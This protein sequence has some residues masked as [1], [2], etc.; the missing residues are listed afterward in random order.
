MKRQHWVL[1]AAIAAAGVLTF[2]IVQPDE[3]LIEAS[4]VERGQLQVTIDEDGVTRVRRHAE[5]TAPVSGRLAESRVRAGDSVVAGSVIARL[6]PAPLDPRTRQQASAALEAARALTREATQRVEQAE[7]ALDEARRDRRR[8]EALAGAGALSQRELEQAIDKERVQAREL[9]AAQSRRRAAGEEE[10]SAEAALRGADP[11]TPMAADH[12][13]LRAPMTGRVL[14]VF[15]EHD[16][17]VPAG[18]PLLEL[19]DTRSIEIVVDLLTRDAALVSVGARMVVR[20][21]DEPPLDAR[22]VRVEPAAFTKVSPLGIE[23][24]RVNVIAQFVGPPSGFGDGFEVQ[25]A[26]V[27]WEGEVTK[28]PASALV[29][30]DSGWAAYVVRNNRAN[31]RAVTIGRRGSRDVEVR[32]GVSPGDVVVLHPDERLRDGSRVTA[33]GR[34]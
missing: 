30:L 14:R 2:V 34:H 32:S 27:L 33:G 23:E 16:R 7:V 12:V 22:V 5:V 10:R 8:S 31:L 4:T 25:S 9:A 1:A 26:I 20:T 28:L 24:Q 17:V 19:G 18:T 11:G 13:L 29:P 3:Y 15:E 6:A 21:G